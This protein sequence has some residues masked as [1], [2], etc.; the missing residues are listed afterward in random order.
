MTSATMIM[1][2]AE[3]LTEQSIN[4][5]ASAL[6]HSHQLAIL[7]GV[8][9]SIAIVTIGVF[10]LAMPAL[11]PASDTAMGVVARGRERTAQESAQEKAREAQES[12]PTPNTQ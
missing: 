6:R 9:V 3:P 5:M 10:T 8:L 7:K 4:R 1:N 12:A 2:S 11:G